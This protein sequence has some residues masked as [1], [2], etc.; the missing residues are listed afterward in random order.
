LGFGASDKPANHSYNYQ[1][2]TDIACDVA[3]KYQI[4]SCILVAHDYGVTVAQELLTRQAVGSLKFKIEKVI[5]F[6]WWYLS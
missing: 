3:A 1:E 5:H 2:Q 6:E 4:R